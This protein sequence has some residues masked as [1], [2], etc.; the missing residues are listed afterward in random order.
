MSRYRWFSEH[1]SLPLA[2]P[3]VKRTMLFNGSVVV[4]AVPLAQAK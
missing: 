3:G 1:L 2:S 4:M